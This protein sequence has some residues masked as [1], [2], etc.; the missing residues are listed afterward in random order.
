MSALLRRLAHQIDDRVRLSELVGHLG[1]RTFGAILLVF[2]IPNLIPLPPGSS[3]VLGIPLILAAAQLAGGRSALWLP[4]AVGN[5]TLRRSDLQRLVDYGLPTLRRTERLL[6]PRWAPLLSE[7]LI[8][9]ACLLLAIILILPIPLGNM[10][11]A[12][13]IAAF[14]LGLLQRDGVA[15]LVGWAATLASLAVV[16][17]V[18]GALLLLAKTVLETGRVLLGL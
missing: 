3:T 14:A 7:R 8:G 16:A 9:A 6:T 17:L 10:L 18:S 12:F 15:V 2:A 13:G 4:Q 1:D 5:R 11:P